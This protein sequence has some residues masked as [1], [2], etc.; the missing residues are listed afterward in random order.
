MQQ[1]VPEETT[2]SL[3]VTPKEFAEAVADI[4]MRGDQ[5]NSGEH[6]SIPE[7]ITNLG[8]DVN[9]EDVIAVIQSRRAAEG[10]LRDA[11][12]QKKIQRRKR[13]ITAALGLSLFFNLAL[14]ARI[15][16]ISSGG[17]VETNESG[18]THIIAG[19]TGT[20]HFSHPFKYAPNVELIGA[21]MAKTRITDIQMDGFTWANTGP[22]D[23]VN[24]G[25]EAWT[26]KG[27]R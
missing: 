26:A 19:K 3:R 13:L 17:G 10:R 23:A 27:V 5:K 12:V 25:E 22:D 8:L 9:P 6:V 11:A 18:M 20:V 2:T 1:L 21:G 4:E 15:S 14:I 16:T 7:A 24:T